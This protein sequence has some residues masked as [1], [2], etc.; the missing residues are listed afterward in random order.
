MRSHSAK[1]KVYREESVHMIRMAL[2]HRLM[3]I[4]NIKSAEAL[5][6]VKARGIELSNGTIRNIFHNIMDEL[7]E[8]QV[9][10]KVC[11]GNW[12]IIIR[13]TTPEAVQKMKGDYSFLEPNKEN[14]EEEIYKE[15]KK[16]RKPDKSIDRN[17]FEKELLRL[18]D[19]RGITIKKFNEYVLLK[20]VLRNGKEI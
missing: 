16:L 11:S 1:I 7:V 18:C 6:I 12:E 17:V 15:L 10:I 5:R 20:K 4:G 13:D 14:I 9:A 2:H 3:V 8:K 19:E